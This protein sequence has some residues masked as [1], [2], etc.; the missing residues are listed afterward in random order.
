VPRRRRADA[1]ELA[2]A[3]RPMI[4][5]PIMQQPW[6][7]QAAPQAPVPQ[8]AA[9]QEAAKSFGK[10][11][12][13][14][15]FEAYVTPRLLGILYGIFLVVLVLGV[16]VGI[17]GGLWNAI[18]ALTSS[19]SSSSRVMAALI[20]VVVTPFAAALYLLIGRM[21][22]EILAVVFRGVALLDSIDKK[23]R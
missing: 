23:T 20:Q 2:P 8:P 5:C 6:Q 9:P 15:K 11:L 17:G 22:F 14:F 16:L 3:Q 1:P 12:F 7:Q 10:A 18:D 19:Y 4:A 21:Y 13:D